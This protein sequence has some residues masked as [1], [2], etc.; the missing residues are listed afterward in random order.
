MN[1]KDFTKLPDIT[2]DEFAL[3]GG[4][5]FYQGKEI[6]KDA[7]LIFSSTE[8]SFFLFEVE[9]AEVSTNFKKVVFL[10]FY[11]PR[12]FPCREVH[13]G[14][15]CLRFCDTENR[16]HSCYLMKYGGTTKVVGRPNGFH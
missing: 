2:I 14:F 4:R 11:Q 8:E 15:G 6:S 1:G 13:V 16:M 5:L 7:K 12:F 9:D 3:S 10:N